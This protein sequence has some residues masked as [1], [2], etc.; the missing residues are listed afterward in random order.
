MSKKVPS[1][2]WGFP[3][4]LGAIWGLSEAGLGIGLQQCASQ[5]SGSIMTG[6]ALFF[7]AGCWALTG[8]ILGIAMLVIMASLFKMFDA[9]LLSL[10]LNSG[11]IA[12]PIFAFITEGLAFFILVAIIQPELKQ[13]KYGQA[14]TGGMAGLL[15][16]NLFPVVKYVTGIPACVFPGT[17][18][19]LS[20]YYAPL[21]AGV[22]LLTV[23]LGFWAG[24]KIKALE[25][26]LTVPARLKRLDYLVPSA[27]LILCLA[28]MTLIRLG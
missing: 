7:M 24:S 3:V 2:Y 23:P 5:A 27:A 4:I 18:Y 19:P 8:R 11:A 15:A 10:P 28:L 13:K 17:N 26:K 6:V 22:S 20:L 25:S 9:L 12:N 14:L 21:A 1:V 16:A